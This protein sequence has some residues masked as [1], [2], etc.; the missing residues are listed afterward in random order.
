MLG[1]IKE[2]LVSFYQL[3]K[4]IYNGNIQDRDRTLKDLIRMMTTVYKGV[5]R[6]CLELAHIWNSIIVFYHVTSN[7]AK[8]KSLH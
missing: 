2:T 1:K 3:D 7:V 8:M 6:P 5:N 4:T